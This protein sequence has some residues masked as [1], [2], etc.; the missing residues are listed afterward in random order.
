[1]SLKTIV[2]PQWTKLRP[3]G[4]SWPA[5]LTVLIPI[6]GYLIIF[7]TFLAHYAD[8]ITE[9]AS[10]SA[11]TTLSVHPRLFLIYFGLCFVA[12]GSAIY[13]LFCPPI[14]KQYSSPSD[15]AG[16]EGEYTG[17]YA[18]YLMVEEIDRS[19]FKNDFV[20]F[21]HRMKNRVSQD[22]SIES[23][24]LE[25]KNMTLQIYFRVLNGRYWFLRSVTT[26]FYVLGFVI[27]LIPTGQIFLKVA[28]ILVDLIRSD[29]FSVFWL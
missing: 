13:S 20:D 28:F 26:F 23:G 7:N 21:H 14:I 2:C 10:K 24:A 17:E 11:A 16:G 29:G 3:I 19:P 27:L 5:R 22:F 6:V 18:R 1:M 12:V 25:I 4:N 9:F 8:L 15:F